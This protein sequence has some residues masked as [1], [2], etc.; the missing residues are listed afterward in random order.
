MKLGIFELM[1][2]KAIEKL[3][4]KDHVLAK[5]INRVGPCTLELGKEPFQSLVE[6]IIYQQL[7]IKAAGTIVRRFAD[8]Y[9]NCFFPSP[10]DILSTEDE[11]LR[12]VGIS[13]QKI[14]YLK[15]LS[16]KFLDGIITP[17]KFS[18]MP[19]EEI[20]EQLTKVLGIGRWTAEMFL[21]F[22]LGRP[23][24]LPI[25]DLGFQKSVQQWYGFE[26]LP[27]EEEIRWI[28]KNWEPYCTVAT[29]YL[30]KSI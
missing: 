30:W 18:D 26:H 14:R 12:E 5:I 8:I 3:K 11:K 16:Q 25:N 22:F 1:F 4:L 24:V 17:S 9:L 13:R 15:D 21:I 19:D 10:E 2:E 6:A 28:A 20:I 29:W 23:N 7:S 27:S